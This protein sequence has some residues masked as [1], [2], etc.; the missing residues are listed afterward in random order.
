MINPKI[1]ILRKEI[2]TLSLENEALKEKL[3]Q[4]DEKGISQL[5]AELSKLKAQYLSLLEENK[6]FREEYTSLIAQ[7][8]KLNKEYQAKIRKL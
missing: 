7:Q 8:R 4:Y 2:E 5:T 6:T 3:K 1:K